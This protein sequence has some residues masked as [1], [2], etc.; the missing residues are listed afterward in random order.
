MKIEDC[1][2]NYPTEP[3]DEANWELEK[4]RK[5]CP[6]DYTKALYILNLTGSGDARAKVFETIYQITRL[7]I[8]D[9]LYKYYSLS[10]DEKSNARKFQT[11]SDGKMYMSTIKDFNDPF[12]SKGYFYDAT[13]LKEIERLQPHEGRL[14]D[15]FSDYIKGT[16]LT[17]NGVQSMPMWAHYSNNHAGFCVSYDMQSNIEL[18][19][20]TFPIQYMSDRLNVTSLLKE[21]AQKMSD[22]IDRQTAL[23][24]K[25][26]IID[27]LTIV[28]MISLLCNLKHVSWNYEH[29]FRCTTGISGVGPTFISAKP[30]EIF[31][32]KN[33]TS[34]H[35]KRLLEIATS[36]QIP[37]YQMR[38]DECS[39][40]FDLKLE[41]II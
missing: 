1:Q 20:C 27:D 39:E 15:D 7:Y 14:I 34:I 28:Y 29:E 23:G 41:R 26:I 16:S 24:K 25:T 40:S 3:I 12:D 18:K 2:L 17:G 8:P 32:G 10:D 30:K 33:C 11:L 35:A 38:Y 22:E 37:I 4:W 19:S 13:Q 21:L 6:M 9:I 36:W 5:D 31:I